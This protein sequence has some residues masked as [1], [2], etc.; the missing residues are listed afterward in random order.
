MT[1]DSKAR[2][3]WSELKYSYSSLE[4]ASANAL[5]SLDLS[6]PRKYKTL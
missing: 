4:G 2:T 1:Q 6:H 5:K 3:V